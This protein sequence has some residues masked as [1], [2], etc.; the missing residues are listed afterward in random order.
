MI[1]KEEKQLQLHIE[2]LNITPIIWRRILVPTTITLPKLHS[3]IQI[4]FAW[5]NYHLHE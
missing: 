5:E 2:L 1:D 4:A 3:V